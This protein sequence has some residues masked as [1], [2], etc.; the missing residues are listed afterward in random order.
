MEGLEDIDIQPFVGVAKMRK[1]VKSQCNKLQMGYSDQQYLI[2]KPVGIDD[3]AK[4]DHARDSIGKHI[5]MA[6][7]AVQIC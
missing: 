4:I 1:I 5:R 3:L 7:Y 6:H 2:F